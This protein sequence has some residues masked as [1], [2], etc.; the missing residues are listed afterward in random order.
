MTH[1]PLHVVYRYGPLGVVDVQYLKLGKGHTWHWISDRAKASVFKKA[2][3]E[4]FARGYR[5]TGRTDD[6][7]I[8]QR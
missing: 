5:A 3:A 4:A 6:L 7:V 1:E 2:R 8:E